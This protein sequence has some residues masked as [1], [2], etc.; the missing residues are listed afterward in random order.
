MNSRPLEE[1][2]RQVA[3]LLPVMAAGDALFI[4][5]SVVV[6][7]VPVSPPAPGSS[8]SPWSIA[9]AGGQVL[10]H[11][12][13]GLAAGALSLDPAV[14]LVGAVVGPCI[15]L[16]HLG[17]LAGLP[18]EA[19][20]AHSILFVA[21]LVLVDWRG[22]IWAKG[23]RNFSLFISLEYSLHLA[24]APPG[25]PLLAPLVSTSFYFSR[26]IPAALAAG[27]GVGFFVD[28]RRRLGRP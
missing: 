14:A 13:S 28:S 22:H 12:V 19:R 17:F 7:P 15:D 5:L 2:A 20:V 6:S 18:V 21:L 4:V 3:R 25:F 10:V 26:W 16:D 27:L 11:V 24:V 9:Y 8:A 1:A 23:T